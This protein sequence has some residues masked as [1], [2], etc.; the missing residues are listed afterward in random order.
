MSSYIL[1]IKNKKEKIVKEPGKYY[2]FYPKKKI[3]SFI[4][5]DENIVNIEISKKF[6]KEYKTIIDSDNED[7]IITLSHIQKLKSTLEYVYKKYL[8]SSLYEKFLND[9]IEYEKYLNS[10]LLYNEYVNKDAMVR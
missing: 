5:Y 7:G 8:K 9:L 3:K 4:I 10:K 2:I 6:L 1:K